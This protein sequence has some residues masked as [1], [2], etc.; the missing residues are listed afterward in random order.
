M[1]RYQEART[2]KEERFWTA[3]VTSDIRTFNQET[4]TTR[5]TGKT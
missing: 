2:D 4:D 3:R 5:I 1:I